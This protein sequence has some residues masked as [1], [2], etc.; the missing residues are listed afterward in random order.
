M[1]LRALA[2]FVALACAAFPGRAAVN[3]EPVEVEQALYVMG[4]VAVVAAMADEESVAVAAVE[5]LMAQAE[6]AEG[7]EDAGLLGEVLGAVRQS[8]LVAQIGVCY[9]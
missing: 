9:R 1:A 7:L 3:G 5:D 2:V 6:R 4:T 8:V